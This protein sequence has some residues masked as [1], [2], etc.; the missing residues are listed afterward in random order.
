MDPVMRRG[1]KGGRIR[2]LKKSCASPI[3]QNLSKIKAH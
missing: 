3:S 1:D 2:L